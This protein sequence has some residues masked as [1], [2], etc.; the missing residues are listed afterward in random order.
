METCN[1]DRDAVLS[2]WAAHKEE[3]WPQVG[4]QHEGPLMTLDTVISGCVVYFLDSPEGLDAQRIAIVE[5]CVSDL[6]SLTD[7]LDEDCQL[8]FQRL[9]QLGTLLITTHRTT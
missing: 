6:D 3:R 2:L 8:Y 4:T 7:D 5:D 9:R 1:M